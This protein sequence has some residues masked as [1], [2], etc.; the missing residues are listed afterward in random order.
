[1]D[2]NLAQMISIRLQAEK[3]MQ[4]CQHAQVDWRKQTQVGMGPDLSQ[5]RGGKPLNPV[6]FYDVAEIIPDEI[7][8]NRSRIKSQGNAEQQSV[9][10]QLP[11]RT[12]LFGNS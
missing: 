9:G 6:V 7:E 8:V 3:R 5:M 2:Q 12:G 10:R 11:P 4:N 1:M